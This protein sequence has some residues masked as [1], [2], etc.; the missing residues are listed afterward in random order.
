MTGQ[1]TASGDR[2]R[3]LKVLVSAASAHGATTEIA[4]E[5]GAAFIRHGG[6]DVTI[7]APEQVRSVDG[8]D[9]VIIGS[10]VYLGHWLDPAKDLV[11]RYHEALTRRPVW[12]FSSGPVGKPTGRLA[13]SMAKDPVDLPELRA[14]AHPRGHQIFAGKLDRSTLNPPQRAALLLLR[15]LNG[16]YRDWG[17]V[18]KWADGVASELTVELD[19]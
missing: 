4:E 19:S 1:G 12:L 9:A 14:T 5:I 6:F 18:R 7:L 15:G 8:Y 16:D 11:H 17:G 3:T 2:T 13:R 10:A